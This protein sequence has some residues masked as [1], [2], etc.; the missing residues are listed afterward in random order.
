M[1]IKELNDEF[2]K[3]E[4]ELSKKIIDLT[5]GNKELEEMRKQMEANVE[6]I[7]NCYSG[8]LKQYI[9]IGKALTKEEA[10]TKEEIEENKKIIEQN[11]QRIAELSKT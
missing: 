2:I 7:S 1:S 6:A 8:L 5:A 4:N 3:H 9:K 11:A 10:A